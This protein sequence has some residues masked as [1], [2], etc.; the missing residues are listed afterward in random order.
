MGDARAEIRARIEQKLRTRKSKRRGATASR[1][2]AE[3]GGPPP[4][5][6]YWLGD[7][8][9]E[10]LPPSA[11]Q[12]VSDL[13]TPSYRR[14]VLEATD[15]LERMAGLTLVHLLWLEISEQLNMALIVGDRDSVLA[16]IHDPERLI[17]EHLKLV[18][19]KNATAELILKMRMTRELVQRGVQAASPVPRLPDGEVID[20]AAEGEEPRMNTDEGGGR[21]ATD[22]HG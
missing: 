3:V 12:A 5:T 10:R 13:V 1:P 2:A 21:R 4:D 20:V 14:L 7:G 17:A 18:A 8:V 11:R 16:T 6:P 15:D 22:E 19:A 9:W